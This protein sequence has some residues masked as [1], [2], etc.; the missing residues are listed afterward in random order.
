MIDCL[1]AAQA[2]GMRTSNSTVLRY[3]YTYVENNIRWS[4][5]YWFLLTNFFLRKIVQI[6]PSSFRI[7]I[8]L[9]FLIY[10][11]KSLNQ[12]MNTLNWLQTSGKSPICVL[13]WHFCI[14][15]K[16]ERKNQIHKAEQIDNERNGGLEMLKLFIDSWLKWK[17]TQ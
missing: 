7:L 16:S 14:L 2:N 13:S 12:Y 6:T 8:F 10:L 17:E 5:I 3:K 15:H 9:Q 4:K 1:K 11:K